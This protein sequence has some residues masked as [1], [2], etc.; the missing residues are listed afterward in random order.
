VTFGGCWESVQQ[1]AISSCDHLE[2]Y[3]WD[4]CNVGEDR[5]H[6]LYITKGNKEDA[7]RVFNKMPSQAMVTWK[8][9]IGTCA[10]W[11]RTESTR[12]IS[13]KATRRC[14]TGLCYLFGDVECT[15]HLGS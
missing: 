10:M 7:G 12:S 2:G 1:D 3:D 14:T 8:A 9:I 15:C 5:K 11:V 4:M 6:S 13:P